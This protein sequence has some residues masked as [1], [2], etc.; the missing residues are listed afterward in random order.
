MVQLPGPR[1]D[2]E[3]GAGEARVKTES[4]Q[5]SALVIYQELEIQQC[6]S[7]TGETC[8]DGVPVRLQLVAVGEL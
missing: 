6:A 8:E 1:L 5:T 4:C 2:S 3:G 7:A